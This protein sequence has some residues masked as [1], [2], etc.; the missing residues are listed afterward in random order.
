MMF[1]I[2]N[3]MDNIFP[4]YKSNRFPIPYWTWIEPELE[5]NWT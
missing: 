3:L 4:H 5:H 1:M 2:E